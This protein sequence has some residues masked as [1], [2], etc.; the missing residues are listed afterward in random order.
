[1]PSVLGPFFFFA[2]GAPDSALFFLN[3]KQGPIPTVN[4][5]VNIQSVTRDAPHMCRGTDDPSCGAQC[6]I[7]PR[8]GAYAAGLQAFKPKAVKVSKFKL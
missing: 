6:W 4:Q 8:S 7:S 5:V 3:V 2:R 1:V